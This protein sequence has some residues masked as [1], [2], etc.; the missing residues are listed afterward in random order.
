M[1]TPSRARRS[2]AP[3]HRR[4]AGAAGWRCLAGLPCPSATPCPPPTP[5]PAFGWRHDRAGATRAGAARHFF[6]PTGFPKCSAA[7][8]GRA[9]ARHRRNVFPRASGARRAGVRRLR[10]RAVASTIIFR[11]RRSALLPLPWPA[12]QPAPRRP[13]RARRGRVRRCATA[14]ARRA[15]D[16]S[17]PPACGARRGF[18]WRGPGRRR[19]ARRVGSNPLSP[20]VIR[21]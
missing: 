15:A 12:P 1:T 9:K 21:G 16:G 18:A 10:R 17:C 19:A 4:A 14:A 20:G 5:V 6:D 3:H 7:R 8:T 11:C 2:R 13:C